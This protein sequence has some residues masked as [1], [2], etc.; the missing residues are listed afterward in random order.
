[1][2]GI[3]RYGHKHAMMRGLLTIFS[4]ISAV[5]LPWLFT[6]V[7]VVALSIREPLLPLAT[8]IFADTLYY[9]PQAGIIPLFTVLGALVTTASFLVRNRL[10]PSIIGE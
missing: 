5:F 7:L 8:G 4:F 9:V 2:G 10:N 3:A 6:F 1:M